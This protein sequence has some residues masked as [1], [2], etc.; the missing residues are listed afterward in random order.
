MLL[1][2]YILESYLFT[3]AISYNTFQRTCSENT[4]IKTIIDLFSVT[5][6]MTQHY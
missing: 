6:N 2:N 1:L 4:Y 3:T 5:N